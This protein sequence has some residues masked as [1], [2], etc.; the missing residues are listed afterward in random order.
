MKKLIILILILIGT[1]VLAADTLWQYYTERGE[2][3]PS[4][5][6]RAEI[7][8][9]IGDDKYSGTLEQNI[10]L[11]KYLEESFG[12][13]PTTGY[14]ERLT[15]SITSSAT[16]IPVSNT[17]DADG[18]ALPCTAT[19]KCYFNLEPGTT[20]EERIVCTG[21]SGSSLTG[22]ARGLPATGS[23]ETG[24]TTLQYA[25]NAGS[26]IIMTNIAQ[27]FGNFVD[28]ISDQSVAGIKTFSSSPIVPNPTTDT[29]VANKLYVDNV[30]FTGFGTSTEAT[31][32]GGYL[33]TQDNM[34]DGFYNAD[35]PRLL[36]T[37]YTSTS[38]SILSDSFDLTSPSVTF[39]F[40]GAKTYNALG[41]TFSP[42][43]NGKIDKISLKHIAVGN[44]TGNATVK[45]YAMSGTYGSTGI[46]TGTALAT[47]D[48]IDVSTI[49]SS[50]EEF[51]TYNF[52]GANKINL[53]NATKYALAVEY[54]GGDAS[55]YLNVKA[56]THIHSGNL[57]VR[58]RTTSTWSAQSS[59]DLIFYVYQD[60]GITIPITNASGKLDQSF[61]DL[62]EDYSWSGIQA[63]T[64]TTTLNGVT[65]TT[66]FGGTGADG[67]LSITSGTTTIDLGS[68]A[69]VTKNYTSISIT[70]TGALAFSN[71]AAGGTIIHLKSQGNVTITTSVSPAIDLRGLG[72]AGG[73]A[74]TTGGAFGKGGGGG[75]SATT[76]GNA[77]VAPNATECAA[78]TAGTSYGRWITDALPTGGGGG[79]TTAGGIAGVSPLYSSAFSKYLKLYVMPGSGGGGGSGGWNGSANVAGGAGGR[80]GGALFLEVSGLYECSSVI[81]AAG[82]A[83]ASGT[84][85]GG[86]GGG[87]GAGSIVI[88]Y[89]SL[90]SDTG[91]YT[92]T[93]GA[94][95][96]DGSDGGEGGAGGAGFSLVGYN[97]EFN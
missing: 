91:T 39:N 35:E 1:P 18:I 8:K 66:K 78:G 19:N 52:S 67:A 32:G 25:H 16:T 9:D 79:G 61:L 47:S 43:I 83:G 89:N 48:N 63:F 50:T 75:A 97:T 13:A 42:K 7:Y 86:A 23:S 38:S 44:I 95:G 92:V 4:I 11:L 53:A 27:F 64:G 76:N 30:A 93:G 77:G 5:D 74:G 71:P 26:K 90:T 80:G 22:C 94:G 14:S 33:A 65:L 3:L 68:S 51:V 12:F 49:S 17:N 84:A 55:N 59:Y 72:G 24:S 41:Q 15:S 10:K 45:I 20:R 88:L 60:N 58:I 31:A 69:L 28:I 82:T 54:T 46:P 87:G 57:S 34:F 70:G 2:N 29:Q 96:D 36:H 40:G 37:R 81:N 56:H 6:E 62:T 21:I 85:R 73:G